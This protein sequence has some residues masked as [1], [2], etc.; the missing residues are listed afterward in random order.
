MTCVEQDTLTAFCPLR[1]KQQ[2][3]EHRDRRRLMRAAAAF[4]GRGIGGMWL[5]QTGQSEANRISI[6]HGPERELASA[7]RALQLI[8]DVSWPVEAGV[9]TGRAL[10]LDPGKE[11]SPMQQ[12]LPD[13]CSVELA[14]ADPDSV[15]LAHPSTIVDAVPGRLLS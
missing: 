5:K 2:G 1:E 11:D 13:P 14:T 3:Q 6:E 15:G 10:R 12:E 7:F 8:L 9:L 4:A